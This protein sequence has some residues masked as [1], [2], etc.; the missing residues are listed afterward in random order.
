MR[1][2]L[3]AAERG[4][5]RCETVADVFISYSRR[6]I[7]FAR[8]LHGALK[9]N[10]FETWI[11]W[12]DIPPTTEWLA[13]IFEAI[14]QADDF[15]FI[16]SPDSVGSQVCHLEI[17]HAVKNNK[18]LI[19]LVLGE[20]DPDLVPTEVAAV[21]WIVFREESEYQDAFQTL[22]QAIR[23]D[24]DWVKAHTRLQVR[25]LEWDRHERDSSHL[26]R[27]RDLARAEA[28][29][30]QAPDRQPKPTALQAEYLLAARQAAS[31]RQRVTLGA[32]FVG[33]LVAVVLGALA[34][35]QRNEAV[36]EGNRRATAEAVAVGESYTRATAEAVAVAESFTRATAESEAIAESHVR[37]TA[38]SEA[39]AEAQARATAQADAEEQR[40]L[41]EY[42]AR[43]ARSGY[44]SVEALSHL[45]DDLDLALLLA[46]E[47]VRSE[48]TVQARSALLSS[49]QYDP[50]LARFLH[51]HNASVEAAAF[52][53]DGTTLVTGSCTS[54]DPARAV[55]S[56]ELGELLFW[57]V[58]AEPG[59]LAS[60]T[61]LLGRALTRHAGFVSDVAF[62]AGGDVLASSG[63]DGTIE[64]WNAATREPLGEPLVVGPG[65]VLAVAFTPGDEMLVSLYDRPFNTQPLEMG[66]DAHFWR[67]EVDL[68]A[69][70]G[71]I[72]PI[73][74]AGFPGQVPYTSLAVS[75][76]GGTMA[77]GTSS[78]TS[79]RLWDL[80]TRERLTT[81]LQSYDEVPYCLAYSPDGSLLAVG[82]WD[83]S[84]VLWDLEADQVAGPPL[85]GH[86]DSVYSVAFSTDGRTLISGSADETV[87]LWD[88]EE[89]RKLDEGELASPMAT[90]T[91]HTGPVSRVAVHPAGS[92]IA[93]A[94]KDRT[95]IL[96]DLTGQS[97][98]AQALSGHQVPVQSVAF[99]PD[100]ATL[101]SGSVDGTVR[102]WDVATGQP[103]GEPLGGH[104]EVVYAVAFSPDGTRLASGSQDN[105][106]RLWNVEDAHNVALLGAP[107]HGHEEP[108][109]S[110]AWSPS[111]DVLASGGMD[112]A[113]R[114]WDPS[115]H[116]QVGE[117]LAL[118]HWAT[119]LAFSPDGRRLAAA[120]CHEPMVGVQCRVE[121]GETRCDDLCGLGEVRLWETAPPFTTSQVITGHAG[122]VYGL[123][124]SPDGERLASGGGDKLVY[125]WDVGDVQSL[126]GP[127]E[128]EVG[129]PAG[130]P[131][132][133]HQ[134]V[135][136]SVAF[137]PGGKF[138]ASGSVDGTVLLFDAET[139]QATGQP[140]AGHNGIVTSVAF[141]PDGGSLASG[142]EDG[143]VILLDLDL[144]FWV[145]RAC[146]RAGRNLS[147]EEWSSYFGAEPY[148][149]TCP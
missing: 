38:Q 34:W 131:L 12:Q 49:L 29:L 98:L 48:E 10:A 107:L 101:A 146:A 144:A 149:Q 109:L 105:T 64:L 68:G 116:E 67:V 121:D 32:V 27:G 139:L 102:L 130:T 80:D 147:Q 63:W 143:T 94:S 96:W 110:L 41:A 77:T 78:A 35:T 51:G 50:R 55:Q 132:P 14:E 133:G 26:L 145:S 97:T 46:V 92:L 61:R 140:L 28:L 88:L 90:L 136:T 137:D 82:N 54:R 138:L 93:S 16:I 20:I 65:R 148:R 6:D 112:Y 125:V 81:G 127:S 42:Q 134:G 2:P 114:L 60:E 23:T 75:P 17:A 129:P 69:G 128:A 30:A 21:N 53:P 25:A 126:G 18:R 104:Q 66:A 57:D 47:A 62:S 74:S 115:S 70:T 106:V 15:L 5:G 84:I 39:V 3:G 43:V 95:V 87:R 13:E 111:G 108:V 86:T 83:G 79:V 59:G 31:R 58:G 76:D 4:A 33:L 120:S 56:C 71:K 19:P 91:A 89:W 9:E 7:A 100:G 22:M 24:Y 1:S 141:R 85:T 124:W 122:F 118:N 52:S 73:D 123:A 44:L 37:A 103:V 11:D 40:D 135:V 117:P 8:L 99:S 45:E 142:G 119:G 72:E 36:R 113:V